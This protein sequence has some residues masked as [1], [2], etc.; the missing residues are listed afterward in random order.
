DTV[1][2]NGASRDRFTVWELGG[3]FDYYLVG[4]FEH[5]MQ[6][7]AQAEYAGVS[8]K[9]GDANVTVFGTG[10]GFAVGPFVGYKLATKVGFTLDVQGGAQYAAVGASAVSSTGQSAAA[11]A[12]SILPLV[13]I[14]IGWSF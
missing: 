1:S 10:G 11:R 9:V 13:N 14:H 3:Q 8:G 7:G 5:G 12:S 4:T 2:I 6:L